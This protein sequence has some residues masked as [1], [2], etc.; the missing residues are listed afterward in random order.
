MATSARSLIGL[1]LLIVVVAAAAQWWREH[2]AARLGAD[3]AA[4]ARPGDIRMISSRSCG[5]CTVAR[6]WFTEH[7]VPFDECFVE[8]DAACAA[9]FRTLGAPGTPVI[10]IRNRPQLGFSPDAVAE[11]LRRAGS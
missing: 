2:R 1:A 4:A 11:A 3:A 9:D 6:L 5:I 10:L 8:T 7:R